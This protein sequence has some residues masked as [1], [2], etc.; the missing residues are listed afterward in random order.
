MGLE[1]DSQ[2][3][4]KLI[5]MA[6]NLNSVAIETQA[7][8][9]NI[10]VSFIGYIVIFYNFFYLSEFIHTYTHITT[11]TKHKYILKWRE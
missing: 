7:H 10:C 2:V 3:T 9:T 5:V 6:D 8:C 1:K 11:H 4:W